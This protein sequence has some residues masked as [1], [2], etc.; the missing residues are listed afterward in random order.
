MR[1]KKNYLKIACIGIALSL[2]VA[3]IAYFAG[4]R[5][6]KMYVHAGIGFI[7]RQPIFGMKP[8]EV[9]VPLEVDEDYLAELKPY[10]FS[11]VSVS[12]PKE[13]RVVQG[14]EEKSYYKKRP[15]KTMGAV[16]YL[17]YQPPHYFVDSFPDIKQQGITDD[18]TFV[19]KTMQSDADFIHTVTDAFFVVMK[20]LFTPDLGNQKNLSM[21]SFE[22]RGKRG[23]I[24]FNLG[25]TEYAYVC[26]IFDSQNNYFKIFLR[27]KSRKMDLKKMF[28]IIS[29]IRKTGYLH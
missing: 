27:D 18:Y 7:H 23:F 2:A 24:S 4:P 1:R 26:D 14:S 3:Y 17:L 22:G 21:I 20:S 25:E 16:V 9:P 15:W 8:S 6:L 19:K 13:F 29:T 11:D 5:L 28:T 10:E 12:L